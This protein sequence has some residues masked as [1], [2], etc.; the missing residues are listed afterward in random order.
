[1]LGQSTVTNQVARFCA[2]D[3]PWT[4]VYTTHTGRASASN[5][6]TNTLWAASVTHWARYA[7]GMASR[8]VMHTY[9]NAS[10]ACVPLM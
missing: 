7:S 9:R 2:E 6:Y 8:D 3:M 1:M 5:S 10:V 4:R